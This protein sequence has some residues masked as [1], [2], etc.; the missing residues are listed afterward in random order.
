MFL[1]LF[2][3]AFASRAKIIKANNEEPDDFEKSIS[4]ALLELE[5]NS[6]LKVSLIPLCVVGGT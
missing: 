2:Q 3:M 4:Q 5:I 1:D 6:D